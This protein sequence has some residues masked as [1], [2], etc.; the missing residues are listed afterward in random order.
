MKKNFVR[1]K[2]R[3][4]EPSVGTW[5]NLPDATVAALMC[6]AGFDWLTVELE[7]SPTTYETATAAFAILGGNGVVPLARLS[8]NTP[9]NIK[10]V[11]DFGA[12]GL[13]VP[14]VNS[15]AEARAVVD[16]ARYAPLGNRSIGG[17]LHAASYDTDS[18]TYYRQANDEI[19]VVVMAEH[20]MAIERADE[21]LAV[22]G[23]DVVF[24]GPNDLT[25]SMGLPPS[26]ES[27]D[28]RFVHAIDHILKAA[29]RHGVVPGIHV[30][31]AAAA[32]R[33]IAQGFQ[34]V[35][36]GSEVGMML[37]KAAEIVGDLGL[38]KAAAPLAKY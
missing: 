8:Y 38:A 31:D 37:A 32:R 13:I 26:F 21:I 20:V 33:R 25:N 35:A 15:A 18:A 17:Q 34:F 23:I 6:R 14:M 11:L 36:V 27:D 7:H 19:L 24:I 1:E 3:R 12:W 16:A 22:P 5:L 29:R 28:P 2:L 4:G 10:R 30:A 9:E